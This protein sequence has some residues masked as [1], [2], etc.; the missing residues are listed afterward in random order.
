MT[1][2]DETARL[3]QVLGGVSAWYLERLLQTIGVASMPWAGLN[4]RQQVL[5]N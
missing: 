2:G 3:Y 4:E 1:T 5:S